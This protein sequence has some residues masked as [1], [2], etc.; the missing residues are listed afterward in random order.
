MADEK[1]SEKA[2]ALGKEAVGKVTG[3]EDKVREAEAQQK[4]S[5]KAEEAER[6]EAEA[7]RKRNQEIGHKGEEA[8]H[9]D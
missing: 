8:K 9:Q 7:E 2:K 5:Q 1:T 4:K 6:L 3:D